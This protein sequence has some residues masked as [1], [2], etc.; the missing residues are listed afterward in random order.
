MIIAL[1][2]QVQ[3]ALCLITAKSAKITRA[4]HHIR[5]KKRACL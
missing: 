2:Q 1:V 3:E 5:P 4:Q